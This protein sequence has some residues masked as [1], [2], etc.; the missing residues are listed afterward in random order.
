MNVTVALNDQFGVQPEV[1]VR[2]PKLFCNPVA[3]TRTGQADT[4]I[5]NPE[6]HL[7]CYK[8]KGEKE[9]RTVLVENQFGLYQTVK[10]RSPRLLCVPSE[11]IQVIVEDDD[12]DD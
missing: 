1:L 7:T 9:K 3:K 5:R 6:A 8:I 2:Q 11:K 4:P 10:V 12:D